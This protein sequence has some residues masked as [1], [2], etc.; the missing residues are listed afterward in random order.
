MDLPN[1]LLKKIVERSGTETGKIFMLRIVSKRMDIFVIS[2]NFDIT[3]K[4]ANGVQITS[5]DELKDKLKRLNAWCK[6]SGLCLG[7]CNLKNIK[8]SVILQIREITTF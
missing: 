4:L 5:S 8:V 2:S 7:F 1:E 3:I 6:V